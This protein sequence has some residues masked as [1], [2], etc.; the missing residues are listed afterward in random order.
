M[1]DHDYITQEQ[2]DAAKEEPLSFANASFPIL[3]PHFVFYVRDTV[4]KMCERGMLQIPKDTDCQSLITRGGLRIYTTLDLP[5]QQRA[6]TIVEETIAANEN[7]FNGHNASSV[8]IVPSTGEIL[9]MVGSRDYFRE[10][11]AG[12]VNVAT[13]ERSPGSTTCST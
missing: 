3:A 12:E 4:A 11:I 6:E 2:A 5:L 7:R 8:V 10:D 13:S 1:V 9:A